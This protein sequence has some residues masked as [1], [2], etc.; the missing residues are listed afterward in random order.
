MTDPETIVREARTV[1]VVGLSNDPEK[2]SNEVGGYLK[3]QG[4]RVIP[5]N[6]KEDEVLG[7]HVYATVDQIPEEVDVV[8]V[9]LPS[10]KTP[11]IAEDAVRAGARTLWLQEGIESSEARRIAEEGGLAYVENR[12]MRKTHEGMQ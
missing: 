10:E 3:E 12:C 4:Y 8:D 6:P 9:F 7:E 1:A 5:V 2:A 11:E